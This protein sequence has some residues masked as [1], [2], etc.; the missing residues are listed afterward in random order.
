MFYYDKINVHNVITV[1]TSN[2]PLHYVRYTT[3][4]Y[5]SYQ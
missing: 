2:P 4:N 1:I 3:H 5:R